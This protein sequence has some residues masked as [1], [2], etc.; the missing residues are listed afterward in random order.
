M[1]SEDGSL[2]AKESDPI[3]NSSLE[4]LARQDVRNGHV[5]ETSRVRNR[6]IS[7]RRPGNISRV[8][9]GIRKAGDTSLRQIVRPLRKHYSDDYRKLLNEEILNA[10]T[11]TINESRSPASDPE[12]LGMTIWS[13]TEKAE[14]FDSLAR[15]GPHDLCGISAYVR[16]KSEPEVHAFLRL[17]QESMVDRATGNNFRLL[18]QEELPAAVEISVSCCDA[19]DL[20]AE[21]LELFQRKREEEDEAAKRGDLWLLTQEEGLWVENQLK[22]GASGEGTVDD[23]IP[24]ANLLALEKWLHLSERIFMNSDPDSGMDNWKSY[25]AERET[26]SMRLAAFEDFYS[27][28]ISIT[29]RLV[30]TVIFS[31]M[32]RIRAM[33]SSSYRPAL[34]VRVAD[35]Q[36]AI[37]SLG[38]EQDTRQFW[39][40]AARRNGLLVFEGRPTSTEFLPYDEVE[41]LLSLE[42]DETKRSLEGEHQPSFHNIGTVE[43]VPSTYTLNP[44]ANDQLSTLESEISDP[45]LSS[46]TSSPLSSP[47]PTH[48]AKP[49]KDQ[50]ALEDSYIDA[51]DLVASH[52]EEERLWQEVLHQEPSEPFTKSEM[53]DRPRFFRVPA[54]E[55]KRWCERFEYRPEWEV[56][57]ASSRGEDLEDGESGHGP[58]DLVKVDPT[59]NQGNGTRGND[60]ILVQRTQETEAREDAEAGRAREE[61]EQEDLYGISDDEV[62][63]DVDANGSGEESSEEGAEESSSEEESDDSPQSTV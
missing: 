32:S 26:P 53:P 34:D 27:L 23:K 17:L 1:D 7:F 28:T 61:E 11:S 38:M 44:P 20:A 10:T 18:T 29:K 50:E 33:D 43:R 40:D 31:A 58:S 3:S 60:E 57:G 36:A 5:S 22:E 2:S 41:Q 19:L 39:K 47:P 52:A 13:T 42:D 46:Q 55:R 35:V 37:L 56:F 14:F 21:A 48:Q 54:N 51:L 24:E 59:R 25:A 63:I 4:A 30:Q 62:M 45:D 15:L 6:S 16:T 49:T 9:T 8:P 12:Q